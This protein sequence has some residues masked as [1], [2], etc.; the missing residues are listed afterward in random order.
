MDYFVH[1]VDIWIPR[2]FKKY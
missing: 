1:R 2:C